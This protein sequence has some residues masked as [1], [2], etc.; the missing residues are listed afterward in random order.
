MDHLENHTTVIVSHLPDISREQII[1][2]FSVFQG[3]VKDVL[4]FV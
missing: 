3:G 2:A 1:Q 4:K